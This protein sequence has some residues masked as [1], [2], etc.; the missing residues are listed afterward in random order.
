MSNPLSAIPDGSTAFADANIF[1]YGFLGESKESADFLGRCR[2]QAL[3]AATTLE[4]VGEVCH[5][6]MIKE[7]K[8]LGLIPRMN[9]HS[10]KGQTGWHSMVAK[11]LGV[12]FSYFRVELCDTAFD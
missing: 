8:D 9:A 4:V 6:L 1:I 7:A 5:R 3:R 11:V 2:S 10:F 12:N